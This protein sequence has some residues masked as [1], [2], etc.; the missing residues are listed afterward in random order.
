MDRLIFSHLDK[1]GDL[2]QPVLKDGID[3]AKILKKIS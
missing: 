2:W 1:V 3:I